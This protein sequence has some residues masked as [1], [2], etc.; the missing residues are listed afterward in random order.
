[1]VRVLLS[2]LVAALFLCAT[3]LMAEEKETKKVEGTF[4]SYKDGTL[5]L[6]VDGKSTEFKVAPETKTTVWAGDTS[7]EGLVKESFRDLKPGT[8]VTISYGDGNKI[9]AVTVGKKGLN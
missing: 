2:A 8:P 6:K 4:E 1:M 3:S 9:N 7:K 5:V